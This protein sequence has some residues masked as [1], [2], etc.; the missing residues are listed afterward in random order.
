[1][2]FSGRLEGIAPSDIFQIISQSKMTGTLIARFPEGTAMVIF[3]DGQVIEAA[4]DAP[5]ESLGYLLVSQGILSE[6]ELAVAQARRKQDSD[7]PLGAILVEMGAISTRT[8]ETVVL[9]QIEHI[10]HRLVSCEDGFIT[11]DRGEMAVKRKLNTDEFLL[12]TGVSAQY[13]IM[14]RARA[15]DEERRAGPA[16]PASAGVS[17]PFAGGQPAGEEFPAAMK[18]EI[19]G[20]DTAAFKSL[21]SKF[22]LPKAAD[23]HD[24]AGILVR[25]AK[26]IAEAA[27]G[28]FH[29]YLKPLLGAVAGK[30]RAFSP[31]GR[32]MVFV[33][34]AGIAAGIALIM[35]TTLSFHTK[36]TGS[37]LVVS[38]PVANIRAKPST[39]GKVIAKTE[40][41]ETISY[42]TS[43]EGW[44]KVR[45]KAGTGWISQK[46][47]ERKEKKGLAV[48]YDMKGFELVFIAGLALLILGIMR[49]K[50]SL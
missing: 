29:R 19:P 48:K 37:V 20:R 17:H 44:H 8:L 36:T 4:S 27:G 15:L 43:I 25:K 6:T 30:V 9:K 33:G 31:D 23:W 11:F 12:P 22:R 49:K 34:I 13:L 10:V 50:R 3:K 28:M 18:K 14:E 45:T 42:I 47:A 24:A 39:T 26:K 7:R 1:M 46:M 2:G 32:A 21:F 38:K 40:Q 41:G 35:L 5:R 16:Q